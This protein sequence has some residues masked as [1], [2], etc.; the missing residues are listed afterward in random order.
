M[1]RMCTSMP[2][3]RTTSAARSSSS[4]SGSTF[5]SLTRSSHDCGKSAA[6][7]IN[8]SGGWGAA[9]PTIFT[10]CWNPQ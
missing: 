4:L 9:F 2:V 8:P 7:V 6:M 1:L 5:M 3:T 10:A